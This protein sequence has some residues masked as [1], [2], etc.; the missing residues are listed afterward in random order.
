MSELLIVS[1]LFK[2]FIKYFVPLAP[3]VFL[4]MKFV[5]Q[6]VNI[7]VVPSHVIPI[8]YLYVVIRKRKGPVLTAIVLII[9]IV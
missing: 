9:K 2:D 4:T 3:F 7:H 1:N 8:P 5:C 6:D